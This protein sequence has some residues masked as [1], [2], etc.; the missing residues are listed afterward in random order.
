[1]KLFPDQ[2][3]AVDEVFAHLKAGRR[4]ILLVAPTGSGK[5]VI[6][7]EIIRRL[8]VDRTD[9]LF[10]DHLREITAQTSDK[11]NLFGVY[12]GII[13]AGVRSTPIAG[14]QVASIQT[15]AARAL[16]SSRMELPPA[17][18]IFID[19]AHHG[20]ANTYRRVIEL[21]PDA[22][23]IGL[24]AT[25]CRGDGR[26]LGG[27]FDVM[28]VCPGVPGLIELGRLVPSRVYAPAPPDLAGVHTRGGDYV[29]GEL[30]QRMDKQH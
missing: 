7:C 24:T 16:N 17:K 15:L 8:N 9:V 3:K 6:A 5:T 2:Q 29:I 30:A 13:Q 22:I 14:V 19:E 18:V 25:P 23:I 1:M 21:Y 28:V 4:R 10:L 27:I 12:A 26:G 20:V 11:L